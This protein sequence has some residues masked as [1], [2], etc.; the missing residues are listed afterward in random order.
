MA[1]NLNL[2]NDESLMGHVKNHDHQAFSI[3][4]ERHTT[5]FY[6]SAYRIVMNKEE[7]EDIVQEAFLK[8]WDNPKIWQEGK[9]A[10]FTTWFYKIVV[11]MALD[12]F[13]KHK[14][15]KQIDI[16]TTQLETND[17]TVFYMEQDEEQKALDVA[18][19][20]L[21]ENQMMALNLCFYED[22]SRKEA[23]DIMNVSLKAL[24]S[25]LMR[26]KQGIKDNLC[27]QGFLKD[28][29]KLGYGA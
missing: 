25:L 5:K 12:K 13:R 20:Q 10:K 22:I 16:E 9:G 17:N 7:S 1:G 11:N 3:L 4:V 23:A 18:I 14:N 2:L 19:K 26:A 29:L 21:P 8:L 27:R 6:A 28:N 24:E 15:I